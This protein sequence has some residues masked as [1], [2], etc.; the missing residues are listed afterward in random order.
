MH[1]EDIFRS[2][3]NSLQN[4]PTSKPAAKCCE[5]GHK[6]GRTPWPVAASPK[7]FRGSLNA[8]RRRR[9]HR[10][11]RILWLYVNAGEPH[12]RLRPPRRLPL[13]SSIIGLRPTAPF[14]GCVGDLEASSGPS[15]HANT[16]CSVSVH[17][18]CCFHKHGAVNNNDRPSPD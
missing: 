7:W 5:V 9:R 6:V 11:G 3:N 4:S 10:E 17:N 14:L 18:R 1:R 8:P 16:R 15:A 2:S 13:Y 12:K